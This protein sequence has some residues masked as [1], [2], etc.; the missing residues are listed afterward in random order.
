MDG[1]HGAA[2]S[3]MALITCTH[4]HLFL[5]VTIPSYLFTISFCAFAPLVSIWFVS[6]Y[7]Q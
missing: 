1:I 7:S 3:A 6:C 2:F 4:S 5:V